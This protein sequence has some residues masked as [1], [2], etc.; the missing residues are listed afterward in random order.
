MEVKIKKIEADGDVRIFSV[1]LK[2]IN[3]QIIFNLEQT[4]KEVFLKEL[5]ID[6]D[7]KKIFNVFPREEVAKSFADYYNVKKIT[8][9][10]GVRTT[11]KRKG[12]RPPLMKFE[13]KD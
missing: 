6:A 5:H 1:S 13:F 7:Y 3:V 9:Q 10:G 4:E 2:G 12:N 11:G 8:I